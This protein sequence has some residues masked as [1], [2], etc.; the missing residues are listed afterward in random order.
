MG[1]IPLTFKG[2]ENLWLPARARVLSRMHSPLRKGQ[3][4]ILKSSAKRGHLLKVPV[5]VGSLS[6]ETE[7]NLGTKVQEAVISAN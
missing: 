4:S 2:V 3:L 7:T 6:P 5:P 1:L